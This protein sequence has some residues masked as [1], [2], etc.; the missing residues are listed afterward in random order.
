ML[1]STQCRVPS[2]G[3]NRPYSVSTQVVRFGW[4][5]GEWEVGINPIASPIPAAC[6]HSWAWKVRVC[7]MKRREDFHGI[8]ITRLNPFSQT[9]QWIL[10]KSYS[11]LEMR[12]Y[13]EPALCKWHTEIEHR[14]HGSF[15]YYMFSASQT[16]M[17]QLPLFFVSHPLPFT[18]NCEAPVCSVLWLS[19]YLEVK[20]FWRFP[21]QEIQIHVTTPFFPVQDRSYQKSP[22]GQMV[23]KKSPMQITKSM[24]W[25]KRGK[26]I[27]GCSGLPAACP[28]P[29]NLRSSF[30]IS[31]AGGHY[32]ELISP[33]GF[34]RPAE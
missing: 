3:K 16:L 7:L 32:R 29:W 13:H 31:E 18:L 33:S 4:T 14:P 34:C 23:W 11:V 1:Q 20:V 17:P 9:Q 30:E 2:M 22:K 8:F 24:T 28:L 19:F 5:C 15:V 10:L 6:F 26:A 25:L 27:Y 12:R 21:W